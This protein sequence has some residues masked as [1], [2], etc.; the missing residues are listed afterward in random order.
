M[1]KFLS[2]L[3]P[4]ILAALLVSTILIV[5]A[6]AAPD[7]T[8]PQGNVDAN[9]STVN[10]GTASP[11]G[12]QVDETGVISNPTSSMVQIKDNDGVLIESQNNPLAALRVNNFPGAIAI[13]GVAT[14]A[15]VIGNADTGT[16]VLG[17]GATGGVEGSSFS[18][19]GVKGWS[20]NGTG[21]LGTGPIGGTFSQSG[22]LNAVNLGTSTHA[23]STTGNV[24]VSGKL[25]ATSIGTFTM[26]LTTNLVNP[27]AFISSNT[28]CLSGELALSCNY[29]TTANPNEFQLAHLHMNSGATNSCLLYAQNT[30]AVQRSVTTRALCFNS[31]L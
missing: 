26:R 2:S 18:G 1:K 11:A 21:V 23:I 7:S 31:S 24:A 6:S 25:T 22:G 12:L 14:T 3:R 15:A 13:W 5:P 16:G 28:P 19:T 29:N 9:F 4:T 30:G 20:T 8:P 27:G 17:S 10:I